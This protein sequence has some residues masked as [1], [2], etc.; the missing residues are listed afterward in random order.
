MEYTETERDRLAKLQRIRANG[1]DPYPPRAH[2]INERV[3]AADAVKLAQ[4]T[5]LHGAETNP[6]TIAVMGRLVGRRVM[7][8]A[9]FSNIEDGSGKIQLF[10]RVGDD[11]L[12]KAT[13]DAFID[14][15][16]GDF[17]EA[18]GVPMLTK[19]GEPSV[20]ISAWNLLSK[21]VSPLPFAKEE[22]QADGSIKRFSAFSDPE[23]RYRQRYADLAVN[24]EVR[25]IF[26]TRAKVVKALREFMDDNDFLEVETPVLQPLYGG[27]AA[28]PFVTHH[29]QL[30]QDLYLRISFE[31][32]LKR[33]LVGNFERVYEIG[34]DFR[35]EGVSFKHNPEFTQI[36]FYAAYWD[37]FMVMDF[38]EAMLHHVAKRVLPPEAEGKSYFRGRE[39]N[40]LQRATRMTLRDA[41][42]D[43]TDLDINAFETGDS[44]A[45]AIIDRRLMP[46]DVVNGK[47]RG[48]LIDGLMGDFVEKTLIQPTFLYDY[49]RDISPLAKSKVG[50]PTTTERFEGFVGGVELCNA[51]SELNDPI[52]QE[53]RFLEEQAGGDEEAHPLD[54]DYIRSQ[55][56]GMPTAGGFGMGVDR[57]TMMFTDNDSIREVLLFPHLRKSV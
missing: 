37:M 55:M 35:N 57:L 14:L 40:W 51:F 9:C 39:V 27:A 23:L 30:E 1:I 4:H 45:K 10:A 24:P 26:I 53:Q 52:D 22:K 17:V 15:D 38:T 48:R 12:D 11:S 19:T 25:H 44:L 6:A 13:F 34:R 42:L 29:N 28:R 33:L 43:K 2:F 31:L 36:E 7:G 49:P 54:E 8:K 18:R 50:D 20:K 21:S 47:T 16:I 56:Y 32:Y 41:I 5:Q 46:A 3:I